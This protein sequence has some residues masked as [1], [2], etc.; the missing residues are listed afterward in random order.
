MVQDVFLRTNTVCLDLLKSPGNV[1]NAV[2][3]V[4]AYSHE[5]AVVV[6]RKHAGLLFRL[7]LL[8]VACVTKL[9]KRGYSRLKVNGKIEKY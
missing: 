6:G 4:A 2:A 8:Q 7:W 5:N 3:E 1:G 9:N